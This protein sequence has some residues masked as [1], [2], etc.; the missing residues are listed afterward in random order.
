MEEFKLKFVDTSY[1]LVIFFYVVVHSGD[2]D[3]RNTSWQG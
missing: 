2:L 3:L 1:V